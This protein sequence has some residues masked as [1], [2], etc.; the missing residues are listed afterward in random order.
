[1]GVARALQGGVFGFSLHHRRAGRWESVAFSYTTRAGYR[2]DLS[3]PVDGSTDEKSKSHT[4]EARFRE[5]FRDYSYL[6]A[7]RISANGVLE[8]VTA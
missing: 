4:L 6:F 8:C 3:D 1:M 5:V 2:I 7:V